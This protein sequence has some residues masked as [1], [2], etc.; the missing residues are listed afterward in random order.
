MPPLHIK[1]SSSIPP[2][3]CPLPLLITL[4]I[5]LE[6]G[7]NFVLKYDAG[8]SFVARGADPKD[9]FILMDFPGKM[10]LGRHKRKNTDLFSEGGRGG[11]QRPNAGFVHVLGLTQYMYLV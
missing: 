11:N 7:S 3:I 10:F 4:F 2:Q 9:S 8:N 5:H 6:S 1:D